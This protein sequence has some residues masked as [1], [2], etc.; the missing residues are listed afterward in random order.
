M[1]VVRHSSMGEAARAK[2][3]FVAQVKH[4]HMLSFDEAMERIAGA[5]PVCMMHVIW[6]C[7]VDQHYIRCALSGDKP[8]KL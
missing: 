3:L 5:V 2:S 6:S 8:F 4:L 1:F 7:I